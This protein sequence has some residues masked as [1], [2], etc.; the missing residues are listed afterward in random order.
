[1]DGEDFAGKVADEA[2]GLNPGLVVLLVIGVPLVA[3]LIANYVLYVYAQRKLP[4]KKK[5]PV[6]KKKLKQGVP[7]PGE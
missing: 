4:T 3:F 2:K 6:S 5:K 7:V 1:M